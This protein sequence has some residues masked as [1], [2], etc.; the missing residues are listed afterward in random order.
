MGTVFVFAQKFFTNFK[1]MRKLLLPA[2]TL[3]LIVLIYSFR[4]VTSVLEGPVHWL[5]FEQAVE[6]AKKN[7]RPIMVDIYTS[8]CGPCKMMTANTFGNEQI[9]KYLN[10]NFYCVKFDAETFD[11]IHLT[12]MVRDSV[13]NKDG[14]T[15][16]LVESPKEFKF[17][18]PAPAGTKKSPHQF[19]SSILDNNL[20]YPSIVFLNDKV[21]RLNI[22]KGYH[23]PAQ[24]EP[25]MKYFGTGAWQKQG[26]D[27]YAKTFKSDLKTQ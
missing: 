16:R 4:S 23:Q 7:P 15:K 20:S 22:I 5:S 8:W 17:Y 27:E 10:E 26:Y 14:K 12:L 11:T 2:S 24:F 25:I 3:F 18:N 13:L 19:A 6:K 21:Q 1:L 9:A